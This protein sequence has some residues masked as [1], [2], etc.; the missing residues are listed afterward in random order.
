MPRYSL[1]HHPLSKLKASLNPK[2]P[3]FIGNTYRSNTLSENSILNQS[4][5]FNNSNLLR[6]T[7]PYKISDNYINYIDVKLY[8]EY[9]RLL[10]FNNVDWYC[11]LSVIFLYKFQYIPPQLLDLN[12]QDNNIDKQTI[13][14]INI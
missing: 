5:D 11:N 9:N 6:N 1:A 14:E 8:D 12:N 10:D 3:Y 13:D 4:F 7:L 2:F